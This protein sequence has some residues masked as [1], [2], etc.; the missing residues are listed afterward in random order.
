MDRIET[1]RL[2]LN[3]LATQNEINEISGKLD[4]FAKIV[5]DAFESI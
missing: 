1:L 3:D 5:S 2:M 4:T